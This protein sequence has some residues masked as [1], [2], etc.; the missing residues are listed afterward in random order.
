MTRAEQ[1]ME[2]WQASRLAERDGLLAGIARV[3]PSMPWWNVE[4]VGTMLDVWAR[5]D[6]AEQDLFLKGVL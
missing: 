2:L 3:T 6:A 1:L 5:M 4:K